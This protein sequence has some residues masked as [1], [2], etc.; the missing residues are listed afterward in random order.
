[1]V[2]SSLDYL[3]VY[4]LL[5]EMTHLALPLAVASSMT[6]VTLVVSAVS[7][8]PTLLRNDTASL[9]LS[10]TLVG[11]LGVGILALADPAVSLTMFALL[12]ATHTTLPVTRL[13][14]SLMASGL[15]VLT[16]VLSTCRSERGWDDHRLYMQVRAQTSVVCL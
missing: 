1:M 3:L 11:V 12:I 2:F 13:A 16:L 5:Q 6:V 14:S 9:V 10:T 8:L 4:C 15:S 7:Q